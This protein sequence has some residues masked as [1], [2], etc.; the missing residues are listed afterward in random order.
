MAAGGGGVAAAPQPLQ[1]HLDVDLP[2]GPAGH[3]G[4]F[5]SPV[6]HN[7]GLDP[8]ESQQVVG[9]LGGGDPGNLLGDHGDGNVTVVEIGLPDDVGG[10]DHAGQTA[11]KVAA[12]RGGLRSGPAQE[13]AGL[14]GAPAGAHHEILGV[15]YD[16]RQQG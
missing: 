6:E 13:G 11:L 5:S 12:D 16:A 7:R 8:L 9:G 4:S 14:K 10:L 3:G 2:Q 15:Q 1:D